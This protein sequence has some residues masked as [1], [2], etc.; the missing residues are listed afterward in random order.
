MTQIPPDKNNEESFVMKMSKKMTRIAVVG[1][2]DAGK[3]TLIGCLTSGMLDN[4]RGHCRSTIMKHQHEMDSGRTSSIGVHLLGYD[5]NNC[6]ITMPLQ[7]KPT[8]ESSKHQLKKKHSEDEIALESHHVVSLFDLAGHEKYLK[9]T[10]SGISKGMIDYALVLVNSNHPPTHMTMEHISLCSSVGIPII[11]VM[12]K[13]DSCPE[14][15][16]KRTKEDVFNILRSPGIQ[17]KPFYVRNFDDVAIVVDKTSSLSPIINVSCVSGEGLSLLSQ[18]IG[19]LPKRR[20]HHNKIDRPFEYLVEE[21]FNVPGTGT[22]VS[23][24]VN[25]GMLQAGETVFV[26]PFPNHGRTTNGNTEFLRSTVKSIEISRVNVSSTVAGNSATLALSLTKEQRKMIRKGMVVLKE[27]G[28][29]TDTFEA[30]MVLLKSAGVDGTTIR[31]GYQTMLHIL[32]IKQTAIME[33]ISIVS[34]SHLSTYEYDEGPVV[35]RPGS[36]AIFRFKFMKQKEY[37]R[38]GMRVLFRDGR[39]RG[40]GVITKVE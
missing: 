27:P 15:A 22:V 25:A 18:L 36:R 3:S 9:T 12:T 40:C 31:E 19:S 8:S 2:V 23:G 34:T 5:E 30:E 28:R 13:I 21:I 39:V 33:E 32:H 20:R 6:S 38:P 26:G 37:L 35:V 14:H 10:I 29:T 16:M 1:N 17:K 4:G 7:M 11:I 24:V